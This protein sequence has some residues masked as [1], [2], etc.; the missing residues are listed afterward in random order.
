MEYALETNGG[1]T[2]F[3]FNGRWTFK[4]HP[5][6][7]E[8]AGKVKDAAPDH[9]IFDMSNLDFMDSAAL[10]M[11]LL[12]NETADAKGM[13]IR[14]RGLQGHVEAAFKLANFG[15]VFDIE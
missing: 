5:Q 9:C 4:E 2:I 3:K 14:V 10:G 6:A 8:I 1:D 13:K 15:E 12:I 11:L 7:V